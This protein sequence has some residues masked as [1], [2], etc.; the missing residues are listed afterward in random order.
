MLL[1]RWNS[2]LGTPEAIRRRIATYEE[3]G[4]QE[5]I[6]YLPDAKDLHSVRLFAHTCFS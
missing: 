2:V 3:A 4:A 1:R 5:I 6:L